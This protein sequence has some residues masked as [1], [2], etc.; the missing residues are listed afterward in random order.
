[1]TMI[2]KIL[3]MKVMITIMTRMA[4]VTVMII[5]TAVYSDVNF[6]ECLYKLLSKI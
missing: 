2:V 1:M 4:N 6:V 3:M 5:M